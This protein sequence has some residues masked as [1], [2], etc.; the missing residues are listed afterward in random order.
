MSS[1]VVSLDDVLPKAQPDPG[2]PTVAVAVPLNFPDLNEPVAQ[3]VRRFTRTALETLI[4]V[5]AAPH[6]VDLTAARL[7]DVDDVLR[8]DGLL[9]LGGGDIDP[10]MFGRPGPVPNGYGIDRRVDEYSIELVRS[11]VAAAVPVLGICRGMQVI[12]VAFGGTLL[13]DIDDYALHHGPSDEELFL[14]ETVAVTPGCWLAEAVGRCAVQVRSGHHQAVDVVAPGL[15]AVA[16]AG[17]GLV[18][19]VEVEGSGRSGRRFVVGVQWHPED[20]H[21]S[22]E[23]RH[24]VFRAFVERVAQPV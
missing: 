21:G 18:E 9:L 13:L 12:N 14:D 10:A 7:P 3:L 2:S 22:F 16:H 4:D 15:R 23:D 6:L 8:S 20:S 11:A 17:D 19:A 5:G 24:R 1:V